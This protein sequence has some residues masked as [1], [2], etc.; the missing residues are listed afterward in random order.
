MQ[1]VAGVPLLQLKSAH[2]SQVTQGALGTS[3]KLDDV[4]G[5]SSPGGYSFSPVLW[6]LVEHTY[7]E[8]L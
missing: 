8:L 1:V 5:H 3:S 7:F 4:G 6:S 2:P